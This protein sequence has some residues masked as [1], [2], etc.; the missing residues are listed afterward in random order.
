MV[1][2]LQEVARVVLQAARSASATSAAQPSLYLFDPPLCFH[3]DAAGQPH[4]S[5]QTLHPTIEQTLRAEPQQILLR[6]PL[7]A[8]IVRAPALRPL[9]EALRVS[10]ALCVVPLAP[11][12][13]IEGAL[14]VPRAARK[15]RLSGVESRALQDFA[16]HAGGFL[17]V[18]L[19]GARAHERATAAFVRAERAEL[20]RNQAQHALQ[21]LNT[22]VQ[23]LRVGG[24]TERLTQPQRAYGPEMRALLVRLSGQARSDAPLWLFAERGIDVASLARLLHSESARAGQPLIIGDCA[25]VAAQDGMAVL[26]GRRDP[27]VSGWLELALGGT[28]LLLDAPALALPAQAALAE[29]LACKRAQ[30][31]DSEQAYISRVRLVMSSRREPDALLADGVLDAALRAN[32][33]VTLRVPPLRERPD[34]LAALL[35]DALGRAARVLGRSAVGLDPGAQTA[36]LAHDWPGNLDELYAVIE[37]AVARARGPRVTLA[38]LRAL[39][40]AELGTRNELDATFDVVER[41]VLERALQRADGNKSE[42]ARLLGLKRST[43]FDKLNR[44]GIESGEESEHP[45]RPLDS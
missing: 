42:A 19:A 1:S 10:D 11:H 14:I 28:L 20:A 27:S 8:Q 37:R 13:E 30:P 3:L 6:A 15:S 2:D 4:Q 17:A 32:F 34:D 12:G 23:A 21:N 44:H 22:E 41:R 39:G 18:L 31:V 7:E 36:L 40:H 38:D 25:A 26:F 16:R 35:L 45:A 9:I 33:T 43:F 29:A 5:A 24:S